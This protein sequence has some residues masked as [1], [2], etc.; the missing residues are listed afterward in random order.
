MQ[1]QAAGT[2]FDLPSLAGSQGG[3]EQETKGFGDL[4]GG[5]TA[6][7]PCSQGPRFGRWSGNQIPQATTKSS[8]AAVRPG[9]APNKMVLRARLRAPWAL[10]DTCVWSR[11]AE[12]QKPTPPMLCFRTRAAERT[13]SPQTSTSSPENARDSVLHAWPALDVVPA[14]HGGPGAEV[15]SDNR[16]CVLTE[17]CAATRNTAHGEISTSPLPFCL[18]H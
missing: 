7:T 8:H 2:G 14:D 13:V 18:C 12:C 6:K 1:S 4:P 15:R 10:T 9:A 16:A 17:V 3:S 11:S 5:P